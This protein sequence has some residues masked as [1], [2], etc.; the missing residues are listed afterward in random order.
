MNFFS[1]VII[2]VVALVLLSKLNKTKTNSE[3]KSSDANNSNA[4]DNNAKNIDENFNDEFLDKISKQKEKSENEVKKATEAHTIEMS[5]K[6]SN[7]LKLKETLSKFAKDHELDQALI[8]LW[9]E[10]QYYNPNDKKN[11]TLLLNIYNIHQKGKDYKDKQISFQWNNVNY[12]IQYYES[13]SFISDD[14]NVDF[15][16]LENDEE[17]FKIN[18]SHSYTELSNTYYCFGID[19]FKKSGNWA[20]FLLYVWKQLKIKDKNMHED[21]KYIGAEDIKKKF[22]E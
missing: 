20:E 12:T 17:K 14:P 8:A 16:L 10:I 13:S 2:I 11:Q 3:H 15:T 1:W 22:E 18:T 4:G 7:D 5:K 21:F 19:T 9:E 6:Y